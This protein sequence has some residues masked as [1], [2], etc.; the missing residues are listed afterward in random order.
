MGEVGI[1]SIVDSLVVLKD[2]G[3]WRQNAEDLNL[4]RKPERHGLGGALTHAHEALVFSPHY[5]CVVVAFLQNGVII[6]GMDFEY[7][8]PAPGNFFVCYGR[9]LG[10]SPDTCP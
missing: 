8:L 3:L 4:P 5:K 2:P 1:V 7:F 9:L 6:Y 10:L